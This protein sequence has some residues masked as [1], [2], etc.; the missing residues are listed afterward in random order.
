MQVAQLAGVPPAGDP[1]GAQAPGASGAAVARQ[2]TPQLDLFAAPAYAEDARDE[3]ANERED[4][5]A[6]APHPALERLSAIDP[7]ELRPRDALDLI[8]ELQS[9]GE[10]RARSSIR[11]AR[12]VTTR[13]QVRARCVAAVLAAAASICLPPVAAPT[14]AAEPRYTFAVISSAIRSPA[15]ELAAQRLIEAIGANDRLSF[16]VY[17]GN[18]KGAGEPCA[19]ALY[20]RREQL[21]QASTIPLIVIPGEHDWA[22]CASTAAGG[23]DAAERLDFLRQTMFSDTVSLGRTR[24]R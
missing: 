5:V 8:Y 21:L 18:I 19:D 10:C 22:A 20:D 7:N 9:V 13:R 6:S 16:V 23:Y 11:G 4:V 14:F 12:R 3:T 15:D 2:L 1:R 24:R 17:D